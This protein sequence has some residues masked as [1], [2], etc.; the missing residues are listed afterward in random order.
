MPNNIKK[1][2]SNFTP[3]SIVPFTPLQ[4]MNINLCHFFLAEM[5]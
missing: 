4:L 3:S 2:E 5:L 1:I